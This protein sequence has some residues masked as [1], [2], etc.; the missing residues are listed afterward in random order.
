M[1]QRPEPAEAEQHHRDAAGR[2]RRQR[3][4]GEDAARP[5]ATAPTR[6]GIQPGRGGRADRAEREPPRRRRVAT[7]SPA[8]RGRGARRGGEPRHSQRLE[9]MGRGGA[10]GRATL[11]SAARTH[12]TAS[13][14][15]GSRAGRPPRRQPAPEL[16]RVG[17]RRQTGPSASFV[18]HQA[19]PAARGPRARFRRPA[20]RRPPR[21]LGPRAGRT[22]QIDDERDTSCAGGSCSRTTSAPRRALVGQWTSRAASPGTYG[23]TARTVVAGP[24]HRL[25]APARRRVG[26]ARGRTIAAGRAGAGRDRHRHG[27]RDAHRARAHEHTERRRRAEL[28]THV[29]EHAAAGRDVRDHAFG[30]RRRPPPPPGGSSTRIST[31][32]AAPVHMHAQADSSPTVASGGADDRDVDARQ[33]HDRPDDRRSTN[34]VNANTPTATTLCSPVT[35]AGG[36]AVGAEREQHDRR[37][38]ESPGPWPVRWTRPRWRDAFR[39]R[40]VATHG[41]RGDGERRRRRSRRR[42]RSRHGRRRRCA[43]VMPVRERGRRDRLHVVGRHEV[44]PHDGCVRLRGAQQAETGARRRAEHDRR[45]GSVSRRRRRARSRAPSARS[46]R[47]AP[48]RSVA[49]SSAGVV[50][51]CDRGRARR[52]RLRRRGSRARPRGRAGRASTRARTGRAGSRA[53]GTCRRCRTGS[54]SRRG[55][56]DRAAGGVTPSTV[57]WCSSIG[58]SSAA[59][60]RG[61]ARLTSS[62]STTLAKIGPGRNSHSPV[63]R[64]VHRRAGDVGRQQVG[65]ALHPPEPAADRGRERLGEQRLARAGHAL[66]QQVAAREQRDERRGARCRAAPRIERCRPRRRASAAT[67]A[68][69]ARASA[70]GESGA[71]SGHQGRRPIRHPSE[72]RPGVSRVVARG[73]AT[74]RRAQLDELRQRRWVS[75][76]YSRH[77]SA[78]GSSASSA[79]VGRR[80]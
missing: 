32:A 28:H 13:R 53:A 24:G 15:A 21:R 22:R 18:Q 76:S 59:C 44:A 26:R 41:R 69:I 25:R 51:G 11:M 9:V 12:W 50:T 16:T 75:Q 10:G 5:P 39:V 17:D 61:D 54:A 2:E 47:R 56:T 73:V 8:R 62:T 20:R 58:S 33:R 70:G 80:R 6:P 71:A 45:D 49:A 66:D 30:R 63:R 48:R 60:V 77:S 42:P 38:R 29:V 4:H 14:R 31:R 65:R 55:R 1:P 46:A 37:E 36:H 78:R 64:A 68:G 67:V 3:E 52:R 40:D 57:T 74:T 43:S 19:A 27:Q 79:W 23:R 34:S 35:R 72:R 7:A